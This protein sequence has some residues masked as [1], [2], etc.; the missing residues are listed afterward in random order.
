MSY[1][2][3]AFYGFLVFL[4]LASFLQTWAMLDKSDQHKNTFWPRHFEQD[5][6]RE[7][8]SWFE[9]LTENSIRI[10]DSIFG[11]IICLV[12]IAAMTL[13]CGKLAFQYEYLYTGLFI[14]SAF[15]AFCAWL[16]I[17]LRFIP[18]WL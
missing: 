16:A 2:P 9:S 11:K 7:N 17:A 10:F 13:G 6:Y 14:L 12:L 8:R 4:M 18:I 3:K 5:N 1:V 15:A